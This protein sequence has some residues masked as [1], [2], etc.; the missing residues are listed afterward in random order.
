VQI[1]SVSPTPTPSPTSAFNLGFD[2]IAEGPDATWKNASH[3]IPWGDPPSDKDGVAVNVANKKM[4][5]GNTYG[6]LLATYP[7]VID[8]GMVLG[9][10]P[11]YKIQANDHLRTKIGFRYDCG[12]GNVK[13][14]IRYIEGTSEVTVGEWLEKCEGTLTSL[15]INLSALVGHTVQFELVVLANGSPNNDQALWVAPRIEH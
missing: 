9:L 14:Q 3:T 12:E 4:E 7:E 1:K 6:S 11:A 15:D 13:Y 5:D 10:Y 2:F 8:D